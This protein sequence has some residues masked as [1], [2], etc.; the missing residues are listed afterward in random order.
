M[1]HGRGRFHSAVIMCHLACQG[2]WTSFCLRV[3]LDLK[4]TILW[5]SGY[6]LGV[7]TFLLCSINPLPHEQFRSSTSQPRNIEVRMWQKGGKFFTRDL[8]SHTLRE[9]LVYFRTLSVTC[10]SSNTTRNVCTLQT[11]I[12]FS[13]HL[14]DILSC[15]TQDHS[16]LTA[17]RRWLILLNKQSLTLTYFMLFCYNSSKKPSQHYYLLH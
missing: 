5:C 8:P 17:R 11:L 9:K 16:I 10:I 14:F 13:H 7:S 2:G 6:K 1:S 3:L 12:L 4:V 15:R